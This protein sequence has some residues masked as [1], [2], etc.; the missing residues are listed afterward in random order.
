MR[1]SI[2]AGL[3]LLLAVSVC[4]A[5]AA[6]IVDVDAFVRRQ[7]VKQIKLSPGGDYYAAI[8]PR[9]GRSVL[10]MVRRTDNKMTG[11]F[12]LGEDS[13]VVGFWWVNPTRVLISMG[14]QFGA[15]DQPRWTGNLYAIDADGGSPAILVGQDVVNVS[16]GSHRLRRKREERVAAFL[17]DDLPQDDRN[18]LISVTPFSDDIAYSRLEKMDVYGGRRTLV[19]RA[20]VRDAEFVT[21]HQGVARFAWGRDLENNNQLY[22]RATD[23]GEWTL[24]N[25]GAV[26]GLLEIPF[27]FAADGRTAYLQVEHAQGPD[28]IVAFDTVAGTRKE[29][30]RDDDTSPGRVI[31]DR[32]VPVGVF[33]PDGRPRTVFFDPEGSQARLYRS[34]EAAF[35]GQTVVIASKTA[36]GEQALVQVSS[37]RN[38]GAFFLFD[39]DDLK[40]SRM[41]GRRDWIDPTTMGTTRPI[42]FD[43]RDGLRIHGFLSLPSG[44]ANTAAADGQHLPL[45]VLVHG[46]PFFVADEWGF[47]PDVQLL[48]S[49][50]YGVLQ[51]NFRGSSQYGRAF[52]Q[53]GA[54]EWGG[55]MQ[56]DVTDATRW[57]IAE[58]IADPDR[59]CIMG[60]SYGAYAA[61]MGVATQPDLYQCAV[62]YVGVYDLPMMFGHGD[63]QERYSGMNYLQG[64]VGDPETLGAV[65]PV[66]LAARIDAPVFLAA[67]GEDERAPIE[68][69][70]K[71]ERA[72]RGAGVSVET[73]YYDSE[74]HGFY[75]D[76]HR[77]EYYT[78]LLAFLSRSLGG[79]TAKAG[80]GSVETAE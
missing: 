58:G 9:E 72:L 3:A 60:A 24:I 36:D 66:N 17:V 31:V 74:G 57:A 16:S 4:S 37:D 53:A 12:S 61:L 33:V 45:V 46:G 68:H 71:M 15:L 7:D 14:E 25:E 69:S 11:V 6:T 42:S 78:R 28:S 40:A 20:P 47:D 35:P 54:R 63:V 62:G 8:V 75:V 50:G 73:L 52:E 59:I 18:V 10:A 29:L 34:L 38:P 64:W 79:A 80:A 1:V 65:S 26:S 19:T 70:K 55:K 39:T 21:D 48:T 67:G 32:S 51:V 30:F 49:A 44:H 23:P 2:L 43:A 27:G 41:V 22:Y 5:T 13:Y 76:A 56:D 77:S